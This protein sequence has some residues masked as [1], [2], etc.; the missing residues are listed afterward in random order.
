MKKNILSVNLMLILL[1]SSK[2]CIANCSSSSNCTGYSDASHSCPNYVCWG[3][4]GYS[5]SGSTGSCEIGDE[6]PSGTG[7]CG[8]DVG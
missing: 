3:G 1:I 4:G 8:C 5:C 7:G 2:I 6:V